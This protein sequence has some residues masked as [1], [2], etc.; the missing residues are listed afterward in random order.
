M[1]PEQIA[2]TFLASFYGGDR[3][4]ARALLDDNFDFTGPFV[5]L[6]GADAFLDS[7]GP[8]IG[9]TT[10]HAVIRSW[11]DRDEVCLIHEVTLRG[12]TEP[13][14]MADWLTVR[15]KQVAIERVIFDAARLRAALAAG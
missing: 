6:R 4:A 10:R 7:A 12:A 8:L 9:R 14:T 13:I 5:A 3:S 2:R 11:S 15:G 1:A